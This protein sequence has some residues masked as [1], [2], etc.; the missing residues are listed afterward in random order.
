MFFLTFFY[1][2]RIFLINFCS[3]IVL[4]SFFVC[5]FVILVVGSIELEMIVTQGNITKNKN[6]VK[7]IRDNK[8]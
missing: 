8:L 6:R 4:I 3:A 2:L 1:F 7:I 5:F